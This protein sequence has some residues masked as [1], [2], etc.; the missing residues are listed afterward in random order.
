MRAA[1]WYRIRVWVSLHANKL[2]LVIIVAGVVGAMAGSRWEAGNREQAIC[3]WAIH[4]QTIDRTLI[5][6]VLQP[7]A[8]NPILDVPS[9][10]A[11]P[12]EVQTYLRDIAAAPTGDT[13][14][15]ARRLQRFRD[16][17]LGDDDLPAYCT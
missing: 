14:T 15:L 17:H 11:L 3:D 5:D 1:L 10:T 2:W 13:D 6:T 16:E 9:F 4:Q 12:P 8:G 7:A